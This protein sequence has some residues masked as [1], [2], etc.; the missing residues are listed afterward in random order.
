MAR[1][2]KLNPAQR[3]EIVVRLAAFETPRAISDSIKREHGIAISRRYIRSLDPT[4]NPKCP[5]KWRRRFFAVRDS[6]LRE[7]GK[8][9]A[10][11]VM[12]GRWRE[13][14]VLRAVKALADQF[15]HIIGQEVREMLAR[16]PD[17]SDTHRARALA[18]FIKKVNSENP[19][20]AVGGGEKR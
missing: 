6:I 9:A 14:T 10:A 17:M 12:R 19:D 18:A 3:D 7:K 5:E 20:G 11:H 4:G 1:E 16:R 8:A 2:P 13:R 15:L